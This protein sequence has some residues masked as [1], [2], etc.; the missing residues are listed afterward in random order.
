MMLK[1]LKFVGASAL[2]VSLAPVL[3][4]S[5]QPSEQ[6]QYIE[7][8]GFSRSC[9]QFALGNTVLYASCESA[10]QG[11][12]VSASIDLKE[13]VVNDNGVLKWGKSGSFKN[14]C[15][16]DKLVISKENA[17][18]KLLADCRTVKGEI[19]KTTLQLDEKISNFDGKLVVQGVPE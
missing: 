19:V 10:T 1:F 4:V 14:S 7:N 13:I 3:T 15:I 6:P 2:V 8:T 16:N 9:K 18:L 5:A 11:K 17:S 12:N